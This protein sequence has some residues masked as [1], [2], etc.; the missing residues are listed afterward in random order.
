[1]NTYGPTETTVIATWADISPGKPVT[2]GRPLPGYSVY[3][4]DDQLRP[5]PAGRARERSASP[6]QESRA[7]TGG[8][9][10]RP[11]RGLCPP[12]RAGARMYRSGDLGRLNG[13]GNLEFL[14]RADGQ[15]KLRGL[16]VELGEIES[17][18]LR[19]ESVAG[20][21]LRACGISS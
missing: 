2:I 15:V 8:F 3:I 18:L 5:R 13:E 7:D 4:L 1:M 21:G 17:A 10:T 11:A 6:A 12:A 16:R 9:P 14:G 19:D 20:G